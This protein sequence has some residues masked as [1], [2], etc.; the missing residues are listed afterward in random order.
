MTGRMEIGLDW[1]WKVV[2]DDI[3]VCCGKQVARA[4]GDSHFCG[5]AFPPSARAFESVTRQETE[6]GSRT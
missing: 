3:V 1:H 6:K 5:N 2:V 4:E